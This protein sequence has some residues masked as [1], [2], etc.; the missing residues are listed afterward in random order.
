MPFSI[1]DSSWFKKLCSILDQR[2][3]LLSCQYFLNKFINH[4]S[5]VADEFERLLTKVSLTADVWT[6]ITNQAYLK[7]TIHYINDKWNM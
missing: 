4:Y 3:V 6:F 2:Y 1:I 7:V 5:L